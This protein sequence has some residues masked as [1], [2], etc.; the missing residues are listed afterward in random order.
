MIPPFLTKTL[1]IDDIFK[2]YC[3]LLWDR[4]ME[5]HSPSNLGGTSYR[6]VGVW[7]VVSDATGTAF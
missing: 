5:N 2:S 4:G 3:P 1:T 6:C 7:E